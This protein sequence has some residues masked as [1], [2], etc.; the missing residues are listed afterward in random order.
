MLIIFNIIS[1]KITFESMSSNKEKLLS[2]KED[3][4]INYTML[5][6]KDNTNKLKSIDI[7]ISCIEKIKKESISKGTKIDIIS[8]L[9]S[10]SNNIKNLHYLVKNNLNKVNNQAKKI[11]EAHK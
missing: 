9:D 7:I 4:K 5:L 10:M 2:T 8:E 3:K 11:E 6:I 1:H